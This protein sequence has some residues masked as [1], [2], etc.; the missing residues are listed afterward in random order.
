MSNNWTDQSAPLLRESKDEVVA[1]PAPENKDEAEGSSYY[2]EGEESEWEEEESEQEEADFEKQG[3]Q[4][5]ARSR[6]DAKL[7]NE[8][9]VEKKP[10]DPRTDNMLDIP[11]ESELINESLK[12]FKPPRVEAPDRSLSFESHILDTERKGFRGGVPFD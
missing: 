10:Y 5:E 6:E 8:K 7:D 9:K 11:D 4:P 12:G 3:K 1:E 2:S